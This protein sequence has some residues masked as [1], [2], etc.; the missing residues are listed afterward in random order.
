MSTISSQT[1][2]LLWSPPLPEEQNGVITGYSVTVTR[3]DTGSQFQLVSSTTSIS[4]STLN[5]F[6][7]YTVT[8][9]ASTSVGAGPQS[10][11]L[12]F[13][14]AEDGK[15]NWHTLYATLLITVPVS[16]PT[17]LLGVCLLTGPCNYV[18]IKSQQSQS[19]L[20]QICWA[21]PLILGRCHSRGGRHQSN[22]AMVS[23]E[24]TVLTS[25]SWTLGGSF[26]LYQPPH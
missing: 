24:S 10:T 21:C 4:I 8:V 5:P 2:E 12:S 25:P 6:T 7:S 23:S 22:I 14:T 13:T 19:V 16:A 20:L 1:V 11:Q 26:G 3:R 15:F 18:L 9:S 17:N